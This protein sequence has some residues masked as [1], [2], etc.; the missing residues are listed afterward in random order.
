[1]ILPEYF[2]QTSVHVSSSPVQAVVLFDYDSRFDIH[3]LQQ[4]ITSF[5]GR[6]IT[7][8]I[9]GGF[10][11][12]TTIPNPSKEEITK[13]VQKALSNLY[14]FQ[15]TSPLSLLASI[16][17]LPTFLSQPEYGHI[18]LGLLC[19]DSLSA[20][21]HILRMNE[22]QHE[23][24]TRLSLSLQTISTLFK[25]PVITTSWTLFTQTPPQVRQGGYLGTGPSHAHSI[26]SLRP[27]WRQYF[28]GE[29]LKGVDAR[30]ILQKSEVRGFMDGATLVEA[31]M[32][33]EKREE[34]V[35]RGTVI[36][37]VEGDEASEFEMFI[38]GSGV[39]LSYQR[40]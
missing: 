32:E 20:F 12:I 39:K 27:V 8:S 5:L 30:I 26:T 10:I 14:I 28:P 38:N 29:W 21:H 16:E 4:I 19:I 15:P 36:G 37:W 11:H 7:E 34:V 9:Q 18:S 23:Y 1:M 25:I 3:R 22:K 35:K 17:G 2:P 6:K 24:Y 31:E 13:V 40:M 33:K